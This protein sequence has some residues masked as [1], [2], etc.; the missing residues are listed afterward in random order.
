M[1]TPSSM[2][3]HRVIS[4]RLLSNNTVYTIIKEDL[5]LKMYHRIK[6]QKLTEADHEKR[7]DILTCLFSKRYRLNMMN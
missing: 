3:S 6:G 7:N 4:Q 5:D 2:N 1:D